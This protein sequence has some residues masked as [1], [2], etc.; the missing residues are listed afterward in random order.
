M[1]KKTVNDQIPEEIVKKIPD[2]TLAV[3][4]AT[5]KEIEEY[6][7]ENYVTDEKANRNAEVITTREDGK[8]I[9][10]YLR[11][12]RMELARANHIPY[13]SQD[14]LS[15]SPCAGTCQQCD[16]EAKYLAE[17]LQVIPEGKR[18]YPRHILENWEGAPCT[19]KL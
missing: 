12:L 15:L 7:N 16:A 18:V 8:K 5:P 4:F 1:N 10:K 13:N 11:G 17:K 3:G 9:C 14:C 2:I 6:D 19:D